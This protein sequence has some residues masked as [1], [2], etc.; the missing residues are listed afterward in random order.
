MQYCS[1]V[2][3]LGISSATV[4][5]CWSKC[6]VIIGSAFFD[7]PLM[8]SC[9]ALAC[10]RVVYYAIPNSRT[11][12]DEL[13]FDSKRTSVDDTGTKMQHFQSTSTF[14]KTTS[15]DIEL[16]VHRLSPK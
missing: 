15:L 2:E 1:L 4:S 5:C 16:K 3:P 8:L 13:E 11:L 9:M 12:Y 6:I 14:I 10:N 7:N